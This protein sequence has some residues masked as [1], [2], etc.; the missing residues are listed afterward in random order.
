MLPGASFVAK[1]NDPFV[2]DREVVAAVVLQD[3][4]ARETGDHAADGIVRRNRS[5]SDGDRYVRR[6]GSAGVA[7]RRATLARRLRDDADAVGGA[8]GIRI[9]E[10]LSSITGKG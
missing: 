9:R 6:D 10:C 8:A 1:V 4:A 3:Q 5:A 2:V 7:A